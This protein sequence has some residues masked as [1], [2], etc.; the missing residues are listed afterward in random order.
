M[1]KKRDIV[2]KGNTKRNT[3]EL[4]TNHLLVI[5]I[6]QYQDK[7]ISNLNNAVRD[8]KRFVDILHSTY[9]F[10]AANT[11]ELYN[12]SATKDR[13]LE[14]FD[15][16]IN[17][18]GK[19]DN[20]IV[21]F[22]GHGDL[23]EHINKGYW[24]PTEARLEK[25]GDYLSNTEVLDFFRYLKVHHIFAIVDAC[26]SGTL[27][28]NIEKPSYNQRVDAKPS[29]WLLSSGALEKVS[30]GSGMHSPFA[31][32][33]FSALLDN[34]QSE[35]RVLDLC[36]EVLATIDFNT[37]DQTPIGQPIFGVG[38]MLGQF[39]FYRKGYVPK[40]KIQESTAS[41]EDILTRS[42][43]SEELVEES[44]IDDWTSEESV[45]LPPP[46]PPATTIENSKNIITGGTI[47]VGG[48]LIIGDG[49]TKE[50]E[51]AIMDLGPGNLLYDI[52]DTMQLKQPSECKVRIAS[53]R[54]IL[55]QDIQTT[56][57]SIIRDLNKITE[58]MSVELIDISGG[59]NFKILSGSSEEQSVDNEWYTEWTFY[60][61]PLTPGQHTLLLQLS[62]IKL[63]NNKER[64]RNITFKEIV[65][66]AAAIDEESRPIESNRP[67]PI[68]IIT[69]DDLVAHLKKLLS[70][71]LE[72]TLTT[73]E[74]I[75][76]KEEE[77][78]NTTI[79]QLGRYNG[80]KGDFADGVSTIENRNLI[81]ARIRKA[82]TDIID[83]LTED[84][85][86]PNYAALLTD[87]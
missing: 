84:Q 15:R 70:R 6:D 79:I 39:I 34:N 22:S 3:L 21:Y 51:E 36:N 76:N 20:L 87:S 13:I 12:E 4:K 71:D 32:S 1:A 35:I 68:S 55:L 85:V 41:P 23:L 80:A 72:L 78:F 43:A 16:H 28:K 86:V 24:I 38:H 66:V 82:M 7:G 27:A 5:G 42:S 81:Y 2:E 45:S 14:V 77:L 10:E 46:S 31:N 37:K 64:K 83:E 61:T 17:T 30:D 62:E 65:E 44:A 50:E 59:I 54:K 26:F 33:L 69:F 58:V 48:N 73:F 47:N 18:L 19:E 40:I 25:R 57:S 53:N 52:P 9:Q 8:A 49:N 63:I 56:T 67:K 75:V 60:V 29:R 74:K 11:V